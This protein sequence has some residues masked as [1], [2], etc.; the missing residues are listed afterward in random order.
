MNKFFVDINDGI[1]SK[2]LPQVAVDGLSVALFEVEFSLQED[3][4]MSPQEF[5]CWLLLASS[6]CY[7]P[8]RSLVHSND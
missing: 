8:C 4:A 2:N 5:G 6:Q 1:F 3:E 7:L